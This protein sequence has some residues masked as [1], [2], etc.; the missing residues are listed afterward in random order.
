ME[1]LLAAALLRTGIRSIRRASAGYPACEADTFV[2]SR[3]QV[4]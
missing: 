1:V 3:G 4:P 2:A